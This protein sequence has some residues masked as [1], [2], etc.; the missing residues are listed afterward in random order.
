MFAD[1][2]ELDLFKTD[3]VKSMLEF[4]WDSYALFHHKFNFLMHCSYI[5]LMMFYTYFIYMIP[6]NE[7]THRGLTIALGVSML[8]P[9]TY[10]LI[11][12]YID[13]VKEYFSD[14]SNYLNILYNL[15]NITNIV[16]QFTH[17]PRYVLTLMVLTVIIIV[18]VA[19]T[20]L[21][22]RIF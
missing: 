12:V 11:Q 15:L 8:Y 2:E 7:A 21:F 17:G 3:T 6:C 13:G 20:F 9:L 19:K 16:L 22:M 1:S 10:C 14:T 18:F 4:K 5:L